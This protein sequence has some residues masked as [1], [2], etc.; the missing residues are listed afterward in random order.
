MKE[1]CIKKNEA[2]QRLDKF[3]K[4]YLKKDPDSFL[5]KMLRKKN[6]TLNGMKASGKEMLA[7]KDTVRLFLSDETIAKFREETDMPVLKVTDAVLKPDI[8]YEDDDIILASKPVGILSQKARPEDVS[9]NELL[10]AYLMNQ[11]QI[12]QEDLSTFR[13]SVCN[14]L[15]R[16]TSGIIAFG[17]SLK[18]T[19]MLSKGFNDRSI[20][21]YYLCVVNGVLLNRSHLN[22]YLFKDEKTNKVMILEHDCHGQTES[23]HTEYLPVF[24]NE[25]NTLLKIKLHTG[26]THQIRAHLASIGHPLIGDGKYGNR[27]EN[28]IVRKKY[29][30]TSQLLH[31]FEIFI[32]E[33]QLRIYAP[34]PELMQNYLKGEMLWEPGNQ[35][36]L[37]AL[38]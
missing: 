21:K 6:I 20:E 10:I 23:I 32:P 17:K 36:A 15:D 33:K 12:T 13:P 24:H 34:V 31:A 19:Q 28:E 8:L 22:G 37:E 9:M 1:L 29:G 3:L 4:K 27:Q 16:N 30:I 5:Y 11:N 2:G 35:E 14:R 25:R 38:H 7:E 18:G 26:K